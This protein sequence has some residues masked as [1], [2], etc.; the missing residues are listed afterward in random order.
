MHHDEDIFL[1]TLK[2]V[3]IQQLYPFTPGLSEFKKQF[4]THCSFAF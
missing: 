3:I 1:S 2:F 4:L